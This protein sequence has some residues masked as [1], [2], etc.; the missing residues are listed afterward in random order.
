MTPSGSGAARPV[1]DALRIFESLMPVSTT[2]WHLF[3]GCDGSSFSLLFRR[4]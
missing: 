1:I 2:D 4:L 3:L